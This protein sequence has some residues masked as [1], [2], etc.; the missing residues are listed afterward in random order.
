MVH[1]LVDQDAI[2]AIKNAANK[3]GFSADGE[4]EW[5]FENALIVE[6]FQNIGFCGRSRNENDDKLAINDKRSDKQ[7]VY[8]G[9]Q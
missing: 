8:Y 1:E 2:V 6:W 4:N 3:C 7:Q 9:P 5:E